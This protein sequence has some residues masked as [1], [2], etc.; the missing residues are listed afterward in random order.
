[1]K[2]RF[3]FAALALSLA[4]LNSCTQEDTTEVPVE[5]RMKPASNMRELTE[6]LK[7]YDAR[8][9]RNEE[10]PLR[11]PGGVKFNK[12]DYAKIAI[13]DVCGGIRGSVG[14]VVG[15]IGGA[16]SSSLIKACKIYAFKYVKIKLFNKPK[17]SPIATFDGN[18]NFPDSIGFF[19]N[20]IEYALYEENN[21]S[22]QLPVSN[23]IKSTNDRMLAMSPNY[24][25]T[26]GLTNSQIS[27]LATDLERM[28]NVDISLS[29]KDYFGK[30][31]EIY[32]ENADIIDFCAEYV[33]TMLYANVDAD[34]YT[35]EVLYMLK[36]SNVDISS[37]DKAYRGIQIAFASIL[38]SE[39]MTYTSVNAQ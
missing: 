21:N 2:K 27:Y 6:Q 20:T 17:K 14:G 11:L 38:Y 32:P 5:S 24:R 12:L 23:L 10:M 19:H 29:Y 35:K 34:D 8:F 30:L 31:K 39:S 3:I 28:K 15:A 22:H 4:T 13:S 33:Y 25:N 7:A 26:G 37:S 18:I 1:M 16:V 36:K 9:V